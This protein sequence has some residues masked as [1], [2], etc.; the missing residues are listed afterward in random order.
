MFF[1]AV[2]LFGPKPVFFTLKRLDGYND[3]V[4][5][6]GGGFWFTDHGIRTGRSSDRTGVF[7]AQPDGSSIAEIIAP[8]D[9]PNGPVAGLQ[10]SL[11]GRDAS[12]ADLV[13][14]P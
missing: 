6:E 1:T 14:G 13:L 12:R 10:S 9:S 4:F 5:D 11:R 7:Y 3:L 2:G 8:L